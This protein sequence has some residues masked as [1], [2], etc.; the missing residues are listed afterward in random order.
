MHTHSI[1]NI[2]T[3]INK[4][5]R[6][7]GSTGKEWTL[8]THIQAHVIFKMKGRK[9]FG[10][11]LYSVKP[12]TVAGK[13]G[14]PQEAAPDGPMG[15]PGWFYME[16]GEPCLEGLQCTSLKDQLHFVVI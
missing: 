16:G 1:H 14:E 11:R 6:Q 12:C 8:K 7:W 9:V 15:V 2:H 10:Q 5:C 3:I 13:P 4:V